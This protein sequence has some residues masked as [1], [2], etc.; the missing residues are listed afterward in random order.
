MSEQLDLSAPVAQPTVT[1]YYIDALHLNWTQQ[2]IDVMLH[3]NSGNGL[4]VTYNG[5]QA[6]A[7]MH[8][9]NTGNFSVNSLYKQAMQK[10]VADGKIPAGTVS[11]TAA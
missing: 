9:L 6:L 5:T 11:G 1:T 7:L 3:D 10:L 4:T 8:A 2:A